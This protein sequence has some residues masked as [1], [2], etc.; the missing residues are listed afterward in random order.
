MLFCAEI[1]GNV[2]PGVDHGHEALEVVVDGGG[3]E[4]MGKTKKKLFVIVGNSHQR[5]FFYLVCVSVQ[6]D[7]ESLSHSLL[8][9]FYTEFIIYIIFV[10]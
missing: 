7:G 3:G 5:S 2:V 9:P 6:H 1:V 8:G 4:L 10:K